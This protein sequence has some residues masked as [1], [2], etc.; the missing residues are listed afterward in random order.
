MLPVLE[1]FPA[2]PLTHLDRFLVSLSFCR[3][4]IIHFQFWVIEVPSTLPVRPRMALLGRTQ[5]EPTLALL[6]PGISIVSQKPSHISY[7]KK[8]WVG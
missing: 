7:L 3:E 8:L 4:Y 6:A 1:T 5:A 2:V